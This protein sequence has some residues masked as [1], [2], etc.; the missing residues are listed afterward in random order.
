MAT[1][2]MCMLDRVIRVFFSLACLYL[3]FV[4]LSIIGDPLL[5]T[6]VGLFGAFN[7]LVI[8]IGICPVYHLAGISTAKKEH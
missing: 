4:D 1:K 7:L 3:G 5:A 8:A 2:N 6:L